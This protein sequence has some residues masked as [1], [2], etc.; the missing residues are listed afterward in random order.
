MDKLA[1]AAR[2]FSTEEPQ[3]A[4]GVEGVAFRERSLI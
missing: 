4:F 3:Y 1:E 2:L